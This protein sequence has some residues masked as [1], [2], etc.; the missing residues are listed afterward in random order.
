MFF[1]KHRE[2]KKENNYNIISPKTSIEGK[3]YSPAPIQINGTVT[4]EI[5]SKKEVVIGREAVVKA[6]IKTRNI[7][8]EGSFTGNLILS[9]EVKITSTGKLSGNIIQINTSLNI[10]DGGFFK[11]KHIITDNKEIF[12]TGNKSI[13]S[14][15]RIKPKKILEY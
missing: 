10:E 14:H 1:A 4:G 9:G 5:I 11:G 7:L 13:I 15:I 3:I 6:N 2:N 12:E 8:I